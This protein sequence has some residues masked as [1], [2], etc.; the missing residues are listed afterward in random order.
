MQIERTQQDTLVENLLPDGSRMILDSDRETVF[1]L[2]ATAGA[3]WDA[4]CGPTTLSAVTE[5]M[6]RSLNPAVTEEFAEEA[7]LELAN[8]NL[9]ATS[10]PGSPS[11]RREVLATLGAL[12]VPLVVSLTLGEQRAYAKVS[13][14][15]VK[16]CSA[17][18]IPIP[19]G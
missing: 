9:V 2:N 8:R 15:S 13:V 3:A 6:R 4:C 12:A 5:Q 10:G 16:P 17:C 7:I 18:S 19:K 14:S 11:T 1:A